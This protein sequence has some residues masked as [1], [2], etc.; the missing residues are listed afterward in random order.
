MLYQRAFIRRSLT[1]TLK[2]LEKKKRRHNIVLVNFETKLNWN[3]EIDN[4]INKLNSLIQSIDNN[5]PIDKINQET[6]VIVKDINKIFSRSNIT[7]HSMEV[8]K[9]TA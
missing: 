5:A 8:E 2:I 7:N 1:R 4:A 9:I 6:S 3:L